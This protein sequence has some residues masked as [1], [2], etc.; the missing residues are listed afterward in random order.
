MGPIESL[1]AL[2]SALYVTDCWCLVGHGAVVFRSPWLGGWTAGP[3]LRLAT[4]AGHW[5]LLQVLPPLGRHAVVDVWPL[6]V[7]DHV[8]VNRAAPRDLGG[9]IHTL[10]PTV[11]ADTEPVRVEGRRILIG[12]RELA[13]ASSALSARLAVR[14]L[15]RWRACAPEQLGALIDADLAEAFDVGAVK[16]RADEALAATRP[17]LLACNVLFLFLIAVLPAVLWRLGLEL[18]WPYLLGILIAIQAWVLVQFHRTHRALFPAEGAERR[19]HL[20]QLAISPPLAVRAVDA[21]VRDA[22]VGFHPLAV[23]RVLLP[24][25]EC[26]PRLLHAL[27]EVRLGATRIGLPESVR[28]A[29]AAFDRR[30]ALHLDRLARAAD[31]DPEVALAPPAREADVS[32]YCPLCWTQFARAQGPDGSAGSCADCDGVPLASFSPGN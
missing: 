19:L 23:A 26:A 3:G 11:L 8:V 21:A 4:P 28:A 24:Q 7:A 16:R 15:A 9:R 14:R 10:S 18:T 31:L 27:R 2:L 25:R 20:F 22:F 30:E 13:R 17:L 12:N 29:R 32:A 5:V 6:A 1:I